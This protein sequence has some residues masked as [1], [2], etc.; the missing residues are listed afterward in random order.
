[1]PRALTIG[2]VLFN[3]SSK[4]PVIGVF[5][6]IEGM[7]PQDPDLWGQEQA[8]KLW[9]SPPGSCQGSH[10]ELRQVASRNRQEAPV[11]GWENQ[12]NEGTYQ[13]CKL[14]PGV[15]RLRLSIPHGVHQPDRGPAGPR[16]RGLPARVG[17]QCMASRQTEVRSRKKKQV[18]C[19][20]GQARLVDVDKEG[21]RYKVGLP[22]S[23]GK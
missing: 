14:N 21:V 7:S 22:G 4:G 5:E 13:A 23:T 18:N 19:N 9:Q 20:Q 3:W 2:P 17:L 10:R 11:L 1:M 12:P 15:N 6:E 16:R 8:C